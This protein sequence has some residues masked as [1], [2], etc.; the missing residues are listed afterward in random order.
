MKD[1]SETLIEIIKE[2][3]AKLKEDSQWKEN[4]SK[5]INSILDERHYQSILA[6]KDMFTVEEPFGLYV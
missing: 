6:T 2:T 1:F 4:F 3:Q 5:Y